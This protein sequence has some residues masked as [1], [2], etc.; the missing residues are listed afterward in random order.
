MKQLPDQLKENWLWQ[1]EALNRLC[2]S[3]T[4]FFRKRQMGLFECRRFNGHV[5]VRKTD[6]ERYLNNLELA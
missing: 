3:R 1:E 5:I 4:T 6:I 2:M